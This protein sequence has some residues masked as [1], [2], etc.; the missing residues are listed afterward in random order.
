MKSKLYHDRLFVALLSMFFLV[1]GVL[2][3][4]SAAEKPNI[5]WIFSEDL[6]PYMG[7]YGD[8]INSGHTPSI[9]QLAAE[10]VIF[11]RAYMPA[12]V[13]SP[14]R[15]AIITGVM[16]TTTGTHQHRSGRWAEGVVPEDVQIQLPAGIRTI[17]ELMR[18]AGYFTF[19]SGK[20][21]YNFHYDRRKLYSVGTK[22]DYLPGMNGWQGNSARHSGS[23]TKD[24]WNAR[25]DKDQPW[26]GQITIWGGKAKAKHVRE[27]EKLDPDEV[28]LPPY[29]PDTE[30]HRKAW[31]EHYNAARGA[32][33]QVEKILA[34]LEKDGE[35]EKTI[36]FF[37]SDHGNNQSL[38][39]KQFCYEG[40]VH[41]PLMIKGDH[42]ALKAGTVRNEIITGLDI[43]ATTLAFAGVKRPDY[44]DGQNLFGDDYKPLDYVIS[45]RDRCDYTIDRIRTVRSAKLRYI[46][47]F[48]EERPLLQAQYRDNQ[49]TV[50]DLHRLHESGELTEYQEEHWFGLRP[51]E[52]L[53]DIEADP[54]QI[55]NLAG[56][57][58]FAEAL[59][60]HRK[61]LDNWMKETDD[62]GQYSEDPAQLKATFDLWVQRPIFRDA[63]VNP[64]YDQF[65]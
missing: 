20:D 4:G 52:E 12:P 19:N 26:F 25:E 47:N 28:P 65:R 23:F 1:A 17:P 5:L 2:S 35:M 61:V 14:C 9:D 55:N 34:Q 7:C 40:G 62:K 24:T 6:S 36:V 64:E 48:F 45:A 13:C 21:D 27:G 53:Y 43:P 54:H 18:D 57:P 44:L 11:K 22:E 49:P 37:F 46:R 38:R 31:T 59:Q 3:S 10:G 42:P 58:A 16:Q 39:H 50:V 33:A 51:K 30:A 32:D 63:K 60:E 41:V 56:D 15:S 29:F 8:P